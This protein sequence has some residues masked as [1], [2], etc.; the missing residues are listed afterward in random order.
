MMNEKNWNTIMSSDLGNDEKP[1]HGHRLAGDG[2]FENWRRPEQQ[3]DKFVR[4]AIKRYGIKLI[5]PFSFFV[6]P[7]RWTLK[8]DLEQSRSAPT[9][10]TTTIT[11]LCLCSTPGLPSLR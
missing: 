5:P 1:V 6:D 3:T 10:P 2:S 4:N 7:S 9:P 11:T 8:M